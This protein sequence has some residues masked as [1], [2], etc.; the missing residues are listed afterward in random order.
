MPW[1]ALAL[2]SAGHT[3]SAYQL[4]RVCPAEGSARA[5]HGMETFFQVVAID[6]MNECNQGLLLATE[7]GVASPGTVRAG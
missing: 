4:D 3:H 7:L 6:W 1:S 5:D 2:P